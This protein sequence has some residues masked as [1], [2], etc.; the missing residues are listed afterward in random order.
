MT[1]ERI[2]RPLRTCLA[3]L[4]A[5]ATVSQ[6]QSAL[7]DD[8]PDLNEDLAY[9]NSSL[10]R[11]QSGTDANAV[12]D[13]LRAIASRDGVDPSIGVIALRAM[14]HLAKDN[15]LIQDY[16]LRVIR[17]AA[18]DTVVNEACA[19][20]VYVA[21]Q[22]GR[23]ALLHEVAEAWKGERLHPAM[24]SLATLGDAAFAEWIQR[25]AKTLKEDDPRTRFFRTL[26][27]K[28]QLQT[29]PANL[30]AYLKSGSKSLDRAWVVRQAVRHG[31][32]RREI[33]SAVLTAIEHETKPDT[34]KSNL[35]LL[36]ACEEC[37]IFTAKDASEIALVQDTR[38]L[39]NVMTHEGSSLT[40]ATLPQVLR[41]KFYRLDLP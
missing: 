36:I 29:P 26:A 40:W 7:G 13:G 21:D 14:I 22:K 33:R 25:T 16:L 32:P 5:V 11:V 23:K 2:K 3:F 20:I 34:L 17:N 28:I 10:D 1:T 4:F 37:G 30:I 39:R 18:N 27:E 38:N 35:D 31:I 6:S 9:I 24:E 19:L 8:R 41:A 12:I 15:A